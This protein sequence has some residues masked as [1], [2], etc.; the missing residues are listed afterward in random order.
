MPGYRFA[1]QLKSIPCEALVGSPRLARN[2][3]AA[4][5]AVGNNNLDSGKSQPLEAK[6]FQRKRRRGC[7]ASALTRLPNPIAQVAEIVWRGKLI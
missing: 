4:N 7:S 1:M 2:G 3:N 5:I 6:V